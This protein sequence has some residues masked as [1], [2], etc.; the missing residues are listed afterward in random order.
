MQNRIPSSSNSIKA[1]DAH[2]HT[3]S[4][5]HFSSAFVLDTLCVM[6]TFHITYVCMY[7][8]IQLLNSFSISL[9]EYRFETFRFVCNKAIKTL[10]QM[11]FVLLFLFLFFQLHKICRHALA[12][13]C[14]SDARIRRYH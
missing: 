4:A 6:F 9:T 11:F 1:C 2:T 5:L 8:L 14:C 10:I 13:K 12:T 7:M 3:H